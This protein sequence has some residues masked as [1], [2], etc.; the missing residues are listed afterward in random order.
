V[1]SSAESGQAIP[2]HVYASFF[3]A[4]EKMWS[5][6]IPRL[7][8]TEVGEEGVLTPVKPAMK[9]NVGILNVT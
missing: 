9:C 3:A 8:E 1:I 4:V 6:K 2:N 5:Q 7:R